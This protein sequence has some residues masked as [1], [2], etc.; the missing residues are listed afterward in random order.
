MIKEI[1]VVGFGQACVDYICP[2]PYFPEEDGKIKLNQLYVKCGGPIATALVTLARLDV[3]TS[4]IGAISDDLFGKI[5]L[6]NFEKE[7][8]DI[9]HIKIIEGYRSQFAFI[10]ITEGKRTI[11][12]IP[13]S[14]PEINP[15]EID[16]SVFPD[17]KVLHL[18][19]LMLD[20]SIEAAKQAKKRGIDVVIDADNPKKNI[21]NLFSLVDVLIIP[22]YLA[23][24]ME[25]NKD[26]EKILKKLKLLGPRQVIITCGKKGSIGYDGREV[27]YQKAFKVD[28]VDTTGAGDV[29]HGAYIYGILKEWDMKKSMEFAS[30]CAALKCRKFG[31]QDGIPNLRGKNPESL[32]NCLK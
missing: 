17:A 23:T 4:F 12:W 19:E 18:D 26:P 13:G 30:I 5:I 11:F 21:E 31:A 28:A 22:E 15:A 29:Y 10:C 6:K 2:A 8:V 1:E 9:S 27:I 20:A 3:K 14:F 32:F 16:L 25:G 24:Q 7:G